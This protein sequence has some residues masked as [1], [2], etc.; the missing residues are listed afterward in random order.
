MYDKKYRLRYLP[1]FY[2]DLDEKV[3]YIAEK[4]KTQKLPVAESFE[5]CPQHSERQMMTTGYIASNVYL[6]RWRSLGCQ[7]QHRNQS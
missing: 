7:S 2:E 5:S 3:T 4:L 1:L 6:K